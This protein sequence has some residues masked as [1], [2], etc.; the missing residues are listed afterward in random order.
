M[1][2]VSIA[3]ATYNGE[4]FLDELL[5][6]LCAQTRQPDEL[7]VSDDCS[8]DSTREILKNYDKRLN[9]KKIYHDKNVW[10]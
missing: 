10:G 2:K 7:V 3:L 4:R 5:E 1:K 6:S 8:T 9:I